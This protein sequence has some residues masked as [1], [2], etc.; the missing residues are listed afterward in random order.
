[1][2]EV[3]SL[4]AKINSSLVGFVAVP[5]TCAQWVCSCRVGRVPNIDQDARV[6]V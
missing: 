2:T 4:L 3:T 6:N 5:G 1:M